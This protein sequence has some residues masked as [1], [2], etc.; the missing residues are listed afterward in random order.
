MENNTEIPNNSEQKVTQANIYDFLKHPNSVDVFV[1]VKSLVV[2]VLADFNKG[3]LEQ[4]K[5]VNAFR[6]KSQIVYCVFVSLIVIA[7]SLLSYWQL[8]EKTVTAT[9]LSLVIGYTI[10][11]SNKKTT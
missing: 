11:N 7:I 10:G 1:G 5:Q 3:K 4:M 8:I 6:F 2:D 9:L